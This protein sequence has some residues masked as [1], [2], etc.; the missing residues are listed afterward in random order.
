MFAAPSSPR[1]RAGAKL[2]AVLSVATIGIIASAATSFSASALRHTKLDKA[3]PGPGDTISYPPA[4]LK[5]WFSEKVD[6]RATQLRLQMDKGPI[7]TLGT[8][9]RDSVGSDKSVVAPLMS[10]IT[11]GTYIV[12]WAVAGAD[13]HPVQGRYSFV[14]KSK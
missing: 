1:R 7:A 4:A 5:L 3:A 14:L 9:G 11:P 10:E 6:L 8:A 12:T 2:I 13:G